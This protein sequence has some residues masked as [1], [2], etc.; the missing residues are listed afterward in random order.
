MFPEIVVEGMEERCSRFLMG[1][2]VGI[3]AL[4]S[5]SYMLGAIN[6]IC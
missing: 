4:W 2:G 3:V 6:Q 5:W 1:F